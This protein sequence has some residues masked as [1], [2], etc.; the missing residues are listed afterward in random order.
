[1]GA[2]MEMTARTCGYGAAS[3]AWDIA[4]LAV[5][6][7]ASPVAADSAATQAGQVYLCKPLHQ[8][9]I[10]AN[11]DK[12][13]VREQKAVGLSPP[14][15]SSSFTVK[16]EKLLPYTEEAKRTMCGDQFAK[17]P[18]LEFLIKAYNCSGA[19]KITA[20]ITAVGETGQKLYSPDGISFFNRMGL[21]TFDP[22][23]RPGET[24]FSLTTIADGTTFSQRGVCTGVK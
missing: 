3:N 21:F 16:L 7:F 12:Q 8:T 5:I 23:V 4:T 9:M 15:R 19:Y 17:E 6:V 11:K 13:A 18:D 22:S 2:Q 20:T 10:I 1:M 14:I 24:E